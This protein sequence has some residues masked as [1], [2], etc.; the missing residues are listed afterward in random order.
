[1]A[2]RGFTIVKIASMIEPVD[3]DRLKSYVQIRSNTHDNLLNELLTEAREEVEK[4]LCVSLV[5]TQITVR[6]EEM[7]TEELPYGPGRSLVSVK[8]KDGSDVS[9]EVEG[10]IG[11][12]ISIKADRSEATVIKYVAGYLDSIPKPIALSIMKLVVD[13]FEERKGIVLQTSSSLPNNWKT[14]CR[15]YRRLS[16]IF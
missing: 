6:W 4:F 14:T 8:D 7:E 12:F 3:L 1:M 10:L 11:D 13:H 16:F 2:T 9:H 5:D 15:P